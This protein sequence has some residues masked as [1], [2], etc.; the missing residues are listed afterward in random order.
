M[1]GQSIRH[2]PSAGRGGTVPGQIAAFAS[3][4]LQ[5]TLRRARIGAS[6]GRAPGV[7]WRPWCQA[8]RQPAPL[9]RGNWPSLGRRG[10]LLRVVKPQSGGSQKQCLDDEAEER[11]NSLC[12]LDSPEL[13][14][15]VLELEDDRPQERL[16]D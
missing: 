14:G 12:S 5:L 9:A 6:H 1:K 15:V 10:A 3:E 4:K 11:C 16:G 13:E 8:S 7:T 2:R